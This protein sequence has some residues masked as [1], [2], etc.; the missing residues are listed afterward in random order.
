MKIVLLLLLAA[1]GA[2]AVQRISVIDWPAKIEITNQKPDCYIPDA[3]GELEEPAWPTV[4]EDFYRR[5]YVHRMD[6]ALAIQHIRDQDQR[7]QALIEC[8][9]ALASVED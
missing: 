6:Y 1:C 8:V 2:P 5:Q 9:R 4:D 3:S 7:I